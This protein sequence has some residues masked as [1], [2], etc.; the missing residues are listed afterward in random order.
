M[1]LFVCT[2]AL[3]LSGTSASW[4]SPLRHPLTAG[5][6]QAL[7]AGI[8]VAPKAKSVKAQAK[9]AQ[10]NPYLA[11]VP[12]LTKIDYSAWKRRATTK[13]AQRQSSTALK[14]AKVRAAG[15]ALAAVSSTTRRSRRQQ[16]VERHPAE[17]RAD[18]GVRDREEENPRVRILGDPADLARADGRWPGRGGQRPLNRDR[19]HHQ[20]HRRRYHHRHLGDGPTAPR[21]RANDFDFYK[22]KS[23]AGPGRI[24]VDTTGS[25]RLGH[26]R[27]GLQRGRETRGRQRRL[28]YRARPRACRY[29]VPADRH[30]LRPGRRVR[31]GALPEDPTDSG[32]GAAGREGGRLRPRAGLA[33]QTDTRLLRARPR[34]GRRH[35][36]HGRRW[37]DTLTV[38]RVDGT[39]MIRSQLS[40]AS[41]L[42]APTSP[43]PGGGNTTL[44]YVAEEPGR[45]AIQVTA[46]R[47]ARTTPT[48]R[49]TAPAR[50]GTRRAPCRRCSSTSTG[51]G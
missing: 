36:R 6:K 34:Q 39:Q 7:R 47:S 22:L 33:R 43:L 2:G 46:V 28:A 31:A 18:P 23:T 38:F 17:R 9:A 44:A 49:S 32:S 51:P 37:A 16:R 27:R 11:N 5:Q 1:A 24:T 21:R 19:Q 3:A 25:A 30:L 4:A 48:S 45:Y 40:D 26:G 12:D 20:R 29:P 50:S 42:Y 41:S 10:I 15:K 8:Q 14:D 13:A 35:R